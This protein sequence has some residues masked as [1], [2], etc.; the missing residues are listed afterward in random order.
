MRHAV[1]ARASTD[2]KRGAEGES[3]RPLADASAPELSSFLQLL[4]ERRAAAAA[5][6]A[7]PQQEAGGPGCVYLVGTGP[8]DPG[9]L[10]LNALRLMQ[11]AD[12]VLH[13]RL[14]SD[15]ILGAATFAFVDCEEQRADVLMPF[16]TRS[17]LVNMNARMVYVGKQSG[18]H[19]RTQDEIHKLLEV[20]FGDSALVNAS[21][22]IDMCEICRFRVPS[23]PS[24]YYIV[25]VIAFPPH[26]RGWQQHLQGL[27]AQNNQHVM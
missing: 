9:L 23:C 19:T 4:Q 6:E 17:G 16:A 11:T 18:F 22:Y 2:D 8:G 27:V 13:D 10:T 5:A 21:A 12:V 26:P 25:G 3:E 7:G 20:R 15:D 24:T 14:V 1:S